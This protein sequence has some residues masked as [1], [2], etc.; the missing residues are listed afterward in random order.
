MAS[1]SERI[2][3]V[4][5]RDSRSAGLRITAAGRPL[6]VSRTRSWR[7]STPSM[8][9]D[10]RFLISAS[11]SARSDM[12][13]ILVIT[14]EAADAALLD[15]SRTEE[16]QQQPG[17]CQR[18]CRDQDPRGEQGRPVGIAPELDRA[19][20]ADH[21]PAQVLDVR[22]EIATKS[23]VIDTTY[24]RLRS[25]ERW[26]RSSVANISPPRTGIPTANG[27]V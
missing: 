10:R 25:R 12:T 23:A 19:V 1:G 26:R 4:S 20:V 17:Q 11:G 6:R 9:S 13:M 5:S 24:R 18:E 27:M 22:E 21:V 2:S 3:S 8:I 15:G 16:P 7:C 14:L